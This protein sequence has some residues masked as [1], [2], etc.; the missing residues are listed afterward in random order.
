MQRN[1]SKD[2]PHKVNTE[3][4]NNHKETQSDYKET[5]HE[6]KIQAKQPQ[7]D[8]L[9]QKQTKPHKDAK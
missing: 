1:K 6:H 7:R 5:P 3:M 8:K 4:Q 9:P 2:K